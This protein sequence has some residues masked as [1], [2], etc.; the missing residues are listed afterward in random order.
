MHKFECLHCDAVFKVKNLNEDTFK[1]QYEIYYCPYCGG[2]IEE[3]E[4]D[5]LEDD[6]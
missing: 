2:D 5:I 1:G 3:E 4:E 6:E